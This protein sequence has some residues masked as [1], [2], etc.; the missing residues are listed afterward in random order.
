MPKILGELQD[1]TLENL[2]SDPSSNVT[3]RIWNNTTEGRVKLDNGSNKRALL[4]NDDKAVIGNNGTANNNVRLH[5]GDTSLLQLTQGGDVTAEGSMSSSLAKLS[6]KLES[7]LDAGKPSFGNSGRTIYLTD[8]DTLSIDTGSAWN[9]MIAQSLYTTKGDL[10][11]RTSSEAIRLG[12]GSNNQVLTADSG[13]ATGMRW[14]TIGTAS[15]TSRNSAYTAAI[16]EGTSYNDASGGGY[17]ITLP[18]PVGNNG[19]S[20]VFQKT[21]STFNIVTIG[22]IT[23]LHTQDESVRIRSNG[24]AWVVE[25]RNIP[26]IGTAYTPTISNWGTVSS[27]SFRYERHGKYLKI[28]GSFTGGT[29]VSSPPTISMPT[30]SIDTGSSGL[31]SGTN[32]PIGRYASSNTS[33]ASAAILYIAGVSSTVSFGGFGGINPGNT[34]NSNVIGGV[35]NAIQV[36]FEVPISGWNS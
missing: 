15:T 4:R 22:S 10:V 13:E 31:G 3:G 25:S 1:A 14:A 6:A 5:R 8:V 11:A 26:A 19:E 20:L 27:V 34:I 2:S 12:I 17:T 23:A 32:I 24:I 30:G 18:S 33:G 36:F 16:G 21:D 29:P 28:N 35:G 9:K 7:Y